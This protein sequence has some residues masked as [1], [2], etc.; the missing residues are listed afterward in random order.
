M[1]LDNLAPVIE[2]VS[3]HTR[4]EALAF[5]VVVA[6]YWKAA[7]SIHRYV[8]RV[9]ESL[10]D[11]WALVDTRSVATQAGTLMAALADIVDEDAG[12]GRPV[13][14][15]NVTGDDWVIADGVP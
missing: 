2:R 7:E 8:T 6:G 4:E 12:R 14:Y 10:P 1:A 9:L 5:A 15:T 13:A 3:P 11:G